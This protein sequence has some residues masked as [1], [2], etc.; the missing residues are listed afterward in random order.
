MSGDRLQDLFDQ[1]ADELSEGDG[2]YLNLGFEGFK[3]AARALLA[4]ARPQPVAVPTQQELEDLAD[5]FGREY[6]VGRLLDDEDAAAF[7]RAV[8]ARWGRP[9][10]EPVSST[11]RPW[12]REGWCD[13]N[14]KF[15]AFSHRFQ[16][17]SLTL[18]PTA[19]RRCSSPDYDCLPHWALP[20]PQE[21]ADG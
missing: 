7:A 6:D 17:W 2:T 20:V 13:A 21:Q 5:T 9:A 14:G 11:K 10:P 18:R 4:E 1:H 16:V 12:E 3:A 19:A 15:W 8:L